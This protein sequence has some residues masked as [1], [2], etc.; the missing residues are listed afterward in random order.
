LIEGD[1]KHFV[2]VACRGF[3][4]THQ[5]KCFRVAHPCE[6]QKIFY[7][8]YDQSVNF[9]RLKFSATICGTLLATLLRENRLNTI[10]GG[11]D[12]H[13][14]FTGVIV[15]GCLGS[16]CG[17]ASGWAAAPWEITSFQLLSVSRH[18]WHGHGAPR[19]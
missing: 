19:W 15:G 8:Q 10:E 17:S 14:N 3:H 5:Q 11:Y 1:V 7:L 2:S 18:Q 4:T 16:A 12:A 9:C 13:K 6:E